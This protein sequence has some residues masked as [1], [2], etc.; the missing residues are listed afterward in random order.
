MKLLFKNTTE[1]T[2]EN[3][4]EFIKFHQEKFGIKTLIK[5]GIFILCIL[6]I[7][8]IN[9]LNLNWRLLLILILAGVCAYI[10]YKIRINTEVKERK[11]NIRTKRKFTF[12]F[13]EGFIKV[14]SGKKSQRIMYMELY[15]IFQTDEHFF[16]YT[17]ED[18]SLILSKEGFEIG[19]PNEFEIF[20]KKKCPFKYKNK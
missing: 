1:Y 3:Y 7:F 10:I 19:T 11:N 12:Y 13:Y 17:D 8:V 6:Y 16:L 2:K 14:K 4:N 20:I 15:K 18:H 5:F 9:L